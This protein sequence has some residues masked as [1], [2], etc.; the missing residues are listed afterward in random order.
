MWTKSRNQLWHPP[1]V[2]GIRLGEGREH[3]PFL[4]VDPDLDENETDRQG[5]QQV[6][7]SDQ[8]GGTEQHPEQ[9]RM[10][11]MARDT[12]RTVGAKLVPD[13]VVRRPATQAST[14]TPQ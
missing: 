4:D 5:D 6:S 7:E 3:E 9:A 10:D 2:S 12:V 14:I 11:R 1:T 13:F 8:K